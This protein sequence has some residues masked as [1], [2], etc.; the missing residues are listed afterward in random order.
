MIRT[1][2][3]VGS[4][5]FVV[6]TFSVRNIARTIHAVIE[7]GSGVTTVRPLRSA[8]DLYGWP[9]VISIDAVYSV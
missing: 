6:S 5:A 2:V 7:S 8:I 4:R 1:V 3:G 9:G